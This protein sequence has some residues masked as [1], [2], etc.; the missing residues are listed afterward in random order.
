MRKVFSSRTKGAQ[1]DDDSAMRQV[2]WDR[3]FHFETV[4]YIYV[5]VYIYIYTRKLVVGHTC[6]RR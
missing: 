3:R 1:M 6:A 4:R 2:R 5:C